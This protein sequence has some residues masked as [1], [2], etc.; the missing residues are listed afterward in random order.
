M[1]LTT[2]EFIELYKHF[3]EQINELS[4]DHENR[5][6]SLERRLSDMTV[7]FV[8]VDAQL[9]RI[10]DKIQPEIETDY[11]LFDEL[12]EHLADKLADRT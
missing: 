3:D 1:N 9:R 6:N 4:D 12:N 8:S 11:A 10:V 2:N 7:N 5:I